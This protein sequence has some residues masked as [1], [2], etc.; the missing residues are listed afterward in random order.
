MRGVPGS[1]P[2]HGVPGRY[3]NHGC[4]CKRCTKAWADYHRDYTHRAGIAVP[5]DQWLN[6]MQARPWEHGTEH[7]YTHHRCRCTPCTDA[8]NAARAARRTAD[9]VR[10]HNRSGYSNGCRCDVCREADREYRRVR[11]VVA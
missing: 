6:E 8:A 5:R 2:P 7:C 9:R 11:K 4:R 3:S 10:T 1:L